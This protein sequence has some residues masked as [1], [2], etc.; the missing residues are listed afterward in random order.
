MSKT[1]MEF[2]PPR[3]LRVFAFDPTVARAFE[4]RDARFV[5]IRLPYNLDPKLEPGPRGKY[6]EVI[7]HDPASGVFYP[8]LN[9]NDEKVRLS[10]GL[11]PAPENPCFHQQMVYAV[12][13]NTIAFFEEALGRVI[14]WAPKTEYN[15]DT[16]LW[17][18]NFIQRLRI[19]PHA[20]REA[21]AFYNPKKKALLFGYFQAPEGSKGAPA[22]TTVFTCLSH[23]VIVHEAV[24]AILDGMHPKYSENSNPEM[25]ALHEAFADIVALFQLFS[26]PNVLE[27]QIAKTKGDLSRQNMLGQLAQEFG[28]SLGRSG[29][30]RDFLG[31][32]E[33]DAET[34]EMIWKALDP[35]PKKYLNAQGPHDRGATLVAAVFRAFLSIYESRVA[36]LFRIASNGSGVL[37]QGEIDPDL[38]VRLANEAAQCAR[39]VL[40]ICIRAMDYM[41]PVNVTFGDYFRAIITADHDLFPED[42]Y[43][44]R[45]AFIESFIAWGIL[46]KGLSVVSEGALLWPTISQEEEN[47][48]KSTKLKDGPVKLDELQA[49][50][51]K[52]VRNP[53]TIIQRIR[54][55]YTAGKLRK[56]TK[57]KYL[58]ILLEQLEHDLLVAHSATKAF[59]SSITEDVEKDEKSIL[60]KTPDENGAEQDNVRI[61]PLELGA[62]L[63]PEVEYFTANYYK[64]LLWF[65]LFHYL[66]PE[67]KTPD[68]RNRFSEL[69][70]IDYSPKAPRTVLRSR[71]MGMPSVH[72]SSV[73][74]AQRV[75]ARGQL[76]QEYIIEVI[77]TRRGYF[78]PSDQAEADNQKWIQSDDPQDT[79][80]DFEFR[81]G[82]T[83]VID[84]N[85]FN[86]RRIIK[87][88]YEVSD[89]KGLE[90]MRAHVLSQSA[91]P[92]N[93]FHAGISIGSDAAFT[94][95]H[96]HTHDEDQ[97]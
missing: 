41:P 35:D 33:E 90:E 93:A 72:V 43:G 64:R 31:K 32:T 62:S 18:E 36:D 77:Q 3:V 92:K 79:K 80:A 38:K 28:Q 58:E 83:F 76:E 89:E 25:R 75:G 56:Q 12:A 16:K 39:R 94:D 84:A 1:V 87:S 14:L 27:D 50:L 70:G 66:Q 34:G 60:L 57:G 55:R 23:D 29:A 44:Y 63:D 26:F 88:R 67:E 7:D 22:G 42:K 68:A 81:A 46:P 61:R 30:L 47:R 8:P 49:V 20:L 52:Y 2:Q 21:N 48:L 19:Y 97:Y 86:I 37:R 65:L 74:I 53:D 15:K 96:R 54:H 73:R 4:N 17:E 69:I 13:M 24:H 11:K 51:G 91:S 82:T 71:A 85:T 45:D 10:D 59:V 6:L 78:D 40:R 95:L 5:K 9:L